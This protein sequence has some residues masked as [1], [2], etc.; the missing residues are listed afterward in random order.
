M[1]RSKRVR[2]VS[3]SVPVRVM[4]CAVFGGVSAGASA[5]S[6]GESAAETAFEP[7]VVPVHDEPHH[8]QL[9]QFGRTRILDLQLPPADRSWYHSHDWP[10]LYLTLSQSPMRNQVPG[11]EWSGGNPRPA[12]APRPAPPPAPRPTSF[13]GYF[14]NPSTHRIEN[15]GD[16]LL[17]ALVVVNESEG[18][19][20]H[21][22]Q[23]AGFAGEPEVDNAWFRAW[24]VVLPAGGST[25]THRHIT[26]V[27]VLQ[28]T[29]GTGYANGPMDFELNEPG[30]WAFYDAGVEHTIS[31]RGDASLEL[32]EV[33]VR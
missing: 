18:D 21:S 3:V 30:Q 24:R 22:I 6:T 16:N 9:F 12:D 20:T 14:D 23:A 8:R 4:A 29:D 25:D 26:P 17:R 2:S 19:E 33:E 5:Q 11:G 15:A 13:T 10:V 28:A 31:N 1:I 27:V 32:I 7:P